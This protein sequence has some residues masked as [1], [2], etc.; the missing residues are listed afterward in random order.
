MSQ[1]MPPGVVLLNSF[2]FATTKAREGGRENQVNRWFTRS[3]EWKIP[4]IAP[5]HM[6][7]LE[8]S[9]EGEESSRR[10]NVTL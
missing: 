3:L 9:Q 10:E 7:Y 6:W 2:L 1:T 4:K 8:R 5:H